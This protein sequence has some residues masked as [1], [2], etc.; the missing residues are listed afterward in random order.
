MAVPR[1]CASRHASCSTACSRR[2][3]VALSSMR[4]AAGVEYDGSGFYGWQR[5]RQSPTVQACVE[6]ALSRVAD[7][8][9]I[10]HCAGRTDTGVHAHCQV[11]HFETTR[12]T[13]RTFLGAGLQHPTASGS[14]PAL[15]ASKLMNTFPRSLLRH[16]QGLS[17][18][19]TESLGTAG[20]RAWSGDLD[21]PSAGRRAHARGGP[22]PV[23]RA[24][25][26]QLPRRWLPVALAGAP[27]SQRLGP[28]GQAHE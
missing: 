27:D 24:R 20:D 9:I 6:E 1:R 3:S 11:I 12:R 17:L 22:G 7:H 19:H 26:L 2:A 14:Q 15:G 23:G 28:P 4:L 8:P 21:S 10:V 25:L 13:Q 5:Q 16:P 18:P